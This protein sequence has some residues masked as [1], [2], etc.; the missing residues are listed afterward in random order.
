MTECLQF[1]DRNGFKDLAM[2]LRSSPAAQWPDILAR[3]QW[4]LE[5][6]NERDERRNM[7]LRSQVERLDAD[8][9]GGKTQL[10][11]QRTGIADWQLEQFSATQN[12][13]CMIAAHEYYTKQRLEPPGSQA[14]WNA[15]DQHMVTTLLRV[16]EH[17]G[18]PKVVVWA[19]NSHVGD[20]TACPT[21]G[22]DF[23]RN[24]TWSLG[25]MVRNVLQPDETWIVGFYTFQGS[26]FAAHQWGER[27]KATTLRPAL[28]HTLEKSLHDLGKDRIFLRL[29]HQ[30][31]SADSNCPRSR[32]DCAAK[33]LRTSHGVEH[34]PGDM[35]LHCE[36]VFTHPNYDKL[37]LV[38]QGRDQRS[39]HVVGFPQ[40]FV[41]VERV[42]D[43]NR[44]VRLKTRDGV[45]VTEYTPGRSV[46]IH[47]LPLQYLRDVVKSDLQHLCS[48]P[49]TLQRWVGVQYHPDTEFESHYGQMRVERAYDMVVYVDKTTAVNVDL[50][51]VG[52][53]GVVAGAGAKT[54]KRLMMEYT[55]ILR[56]PIPHIQA[57]PLE[58]NILEWHFVISGT[59]E[60]YLGGKYHGVMEFPESFPMQPPGIKMLTPSGRFEINTRICV[61]M[62]DFHP[63][64]WNPAWNVETILLGLQSFMYEDTGGTKKKE[65][66]IGSL[67]DTAENRTKYAMESQR[68]NMRND[69]YVELF[70]GELAEAS[71]PTPTSR[72]PQLDE[73][74][75]VCRFCFNGGDLIAPCACKGSTK[76]VHK[77]CLEQWQK[78][79]LLTQSTHPKYQSKIDEFCNIC[80][81]RFK[82]RGKSRRE[83]VLEYT[84]P[85]LAA[86]IQRGA[87]IVTS[88]HDSEGHE[89]AMEK[90]PDLTA[91]L[92][93]W[94]RAVYLIA[95]GD[96]RG[97]VA[98]NL[99]RAV[100]APPEK[101]RAGLRGESSVY[102]ARVW[103]TR[104]RA[105]AASPFVQRVQ[106]YIGGPVEPDSILTT[107]EAPSECVP[108]RLRTV[109]VK[110]GLYFG[111]LDSI[112][113]I[114]ASVFNYT[115]KQSVVK[116]FWGYASWGYTQLLSELAK[117]SWGLVL[118][119][120]YTDAL[121]WE[122]VVD[123]V[124]IA[125]ESEYS[126]ALL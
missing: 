64:S 49:G 48:F 98:F 55:R 40:S 16:R 8:L 53:T 10:R 29:A 43:A 27:G 67:Y 109:E 112:L 11:D 73:S 118:S 123:E 2:Q 72:A 108:P 107:V 13:E 116:V 1:L 121:N 69:I 7:A 124:L 93:H 46:S 78:S 37:K 85:E 106:H 101:V 62:S 117:R 54:N 76:W 86:L 3:L 20:S 41:P 26:V 103:A 25:Q 66:A 111:D 5:K 39:R 35:P 12:L 77:S 50:S 24:E 21:G 100:E 83:A 45:Y 97:V 56:S 33:R 114:A 122:D 58:H 105:V 59:Q 92:S 104:A 28:D 36:Y 34:N 81:T 90:H 4:D 110:K 17:L 51:Q 119:D 120:K 102:P 96:E 75:D 99:T 70:S 6:L 22:A 42:M 95:R 52:G 14:S 65:L 61:S 80:E 126:K 44:S 115:G 31:Q 91:S 82:M 74:G 15:R 87:M 84:G 57:H 68:F 38:T 79:V 9:V 94:T 63:D 30:E 18:C 89:E 32:S 113:S 23:E 60:P 88:R 47:C 125:K 71:G 19:H